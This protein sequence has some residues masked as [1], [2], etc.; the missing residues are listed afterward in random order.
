MEIGFVLIALFTA[1]VLTL[2]FR[3]ESNKKSNR[4]RL[5]GRG[6]DFEG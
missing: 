4:P 6:G 1:S 3:Y 2:I 5:T